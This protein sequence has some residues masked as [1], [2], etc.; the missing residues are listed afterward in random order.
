MELFEENK[1]KAVKLQMQ[2]DTTEKKIDQMFYA[3]YGLS[4]EEIG[5]VEGS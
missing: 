1:K 5:I 2:I 3:S 4:E